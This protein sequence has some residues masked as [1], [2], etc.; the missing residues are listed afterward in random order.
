MVIGACTPR[1]AAFLSKNLR[2]HFSSLNSHQ[3]KAGGP[4]KEKVRREY[5][6]LTSGL[7]GESMSVSMSMRGIYI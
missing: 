3:P 5:L 7:D 6:I 4:L 1:G 2:R